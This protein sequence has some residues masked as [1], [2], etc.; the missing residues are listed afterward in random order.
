MNRSKPKTKNLPLSTKP[1]H[2]P[3]TEPSKPSPNTNLKQLILSKLKFDDSGKCISGYEVIRDPETIRQAYFHIKSKPGNMTVGTDGAT[4]DGINTKFLTGLAE[5]LHSSKYQPSPTRRIYIPKKNGK[6]RPLGIGSPR[7]KIIEQ[8]FLFVLESVLEPKFSDHSHGFRPIRGCHTALKQLR[9][10]NGVP[11]FIEG[12]IKEFFSSLNHHVLADRLKLHFNDTRLMDLYWKFV[13]AGYVEWD[14]NRRKVLDLIYGVPQGS[15]I[16]P[17]MSN[18]YL[19]D[20]DIY[21]QDKQKAMT[22]RNKGQKNPYIKNPEYNS[23]TLKI[24][25]RYEKIKT[26]TDSSKITEIRKEIKGLISLRRKTKSVINNPNFGPTIK[27]VRYADDWLIGVWG[28]YSEVKS[29]REE[30]R[31]FLLDRLNLE[32]NLDKTLITNAKTEKARFLGVNINRNIANT[33]Q[34]LHSSDSNSSY[35][36]QKHRSTRAGQVLMYAPIMD[37]VKRLEDNGIIQTEKD[38]QWISQS[39]PH[40]ISLPVKDIILR[41]RTILNGYV[42]YYSFADNKKQLRKIHWLLKESLIKTLCRKLDCGR[43]E[44]LRRFGKK[45]QTIYQMKNTTKRISFSCPPLPYSPMHFQG[46]TRFT[47]PVLASKWKIRSLNLLDAPCAS[48][49]SKTNVEVHHIRHIRTI[50]LKL[51]TFDQKLA[52]IN[53]KQVPL[54]RECHRKVHQGKYK[55]LS[56]KHLATGR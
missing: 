41:Y 10:W 54:C 23:L 31:T 39:I 16:S 22:E 21:I 12:D 11:W 29:I 56:L 24:R 14:S 37:I 8:A 25:R 38:K 42:N 32:L 47:D 5:S 17:I 7:D 45:V 30:I 1:A 34:K 6:L 40:L 33:R 50:N 28:K 55:G 27:Y 2:K 19:H 18:L 49:D 26:I 52:A 51:N 9:T 53:R 13:R 44:I 15:I 3:R 36:G 48:C 20:L 46:T 4:L 43:R 35:K